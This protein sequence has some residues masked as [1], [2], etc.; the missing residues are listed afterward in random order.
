M[1]NNHVNVEYLA[2]QVDIIASN[3]EHIYNERMNTRRKLR[4]IAIGELMFFINQELKFSGYPGYY[5]DNK[6]VMAFDKEHFGDL[7]KVLDILEGY[8]METRKERNA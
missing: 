2:D 1:D 7:E 6:Q 5:A 8:I 4:N 3:T